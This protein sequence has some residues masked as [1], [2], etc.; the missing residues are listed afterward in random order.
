MSKV[1]VLNSLKFVLVCTSCF[2]LF[3][4]IF[5]KNKAC[6]TMTP[7]TQSKEGLSMMSALATTVYDDDSY[8]DHSRQSNRFCGILS[9]VMLRA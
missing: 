7:S 6:I 3:Q 4:T 9:E 1:N 5:N 8:K 2:K